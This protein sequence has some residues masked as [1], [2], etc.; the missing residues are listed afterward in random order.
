MGHGGGV[1]EVV[2]LSGYCGAG[3]LLLTVLS[4]CRSEFS[5]GSGL[6]STPR[7][8]SQP[9]MWVLEKM[10][11]ECL[12][13]EETMEPC[14]FVRH[15]NGALSLEKSYQSRCP[16]RSKHKC[17]LLNCSFRTN[18]ESQSLE[19]VYRLMSTY[20]MACPYSRATEPHKGIK[21]PYLL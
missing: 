2:V 16:Q 5:V 19:H 11:A 3:L 10:D 6:P 1:G 14:S 15:G 8:T 20:N 4:S 7:C 17:S 12:R 9:C 13:D 21:L 18:A